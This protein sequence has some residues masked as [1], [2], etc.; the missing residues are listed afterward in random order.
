MSMPKSEERAL[1]AIAE[2]CAETRRPIKTMIVMAALNVKTGAPADALLVDLCSLKRQGLITQ[3]DD[4]WEA[5]PE[6]HKAA[7][8]IMAGQ[9]LPKPRL[10]PITEPSKPRDT[11]RPRAL[12]APKPITRPE[13][14]TVKDSLT[15]QVCAGCGSTGGQFHSPECPAVNAFTAGRIHGGGDGEALGII[16]YPA[17]LERLGPPI[18]LELLNRCAA[19]H[20]ALLPEVQG[21]YERGEEGAAAELAWM[22]ETGRQLLAAGGEG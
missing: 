19:M 14:A 16:E 18:S 11:L 6:G 21:A 7:R 5:T 13:P 9:A 20:L 3:H 8:Q 10:E 15:P 1:V 22:I 2:Q 4:T 12:T 17:S